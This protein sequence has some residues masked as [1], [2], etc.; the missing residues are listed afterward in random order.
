[1]IKNGY[2]DYLLLKIN[3]E[4]G[5]T[6]SK[7]VMLVMM[8]VT[9]VSSLA[10]VTSVL[11]K[12]AV[13]ENKVLVNDMKDEQVGMSREDKRAKMK[14]YLME[15]NKKR[16]T[17]KRP[18][19]CV[20]S[21]PIDATTNK[22]VQIRGTMFLSSGSNNSIINRPRHYLINCQCGETQC[23]LSEDKGTFCLK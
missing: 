8:M 1:M 23:V 3:H 17:M 5:N 14:A 20:C 9:I 4:E 18:K 22:I 19:E 16:M 6:M 15:Q 11:T 12:S 2:Y 13:A 21:Q 10:M 7:K